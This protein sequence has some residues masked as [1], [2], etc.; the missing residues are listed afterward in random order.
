MRNLIQFIPRHWVALDYLTKIRAVVT[1]FVLSSLC[2]FQ[3]APQEL[4]SNDKEKFAQFYL[5]DVASKDEYKEIEHYLR[6]QKGILK[7]Q[8]D[9]LSGIAFCIFSVNADIDETSFVHWL[10][11]EGYTFSCYREGIHGVDPVFS[12]ENFHCM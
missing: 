5:T 11:K 7:V 2:A 10:S 6:A 1:L 8:V 9:A 3:Q 12:K 4:E